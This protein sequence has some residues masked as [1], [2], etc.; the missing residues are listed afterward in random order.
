ML[1]P[2]G[3][4]SRQTSRL[5]YRPKRRYLPLPFISVIFWFIYNHRKKVIPVTGRGGP[6][7]CE[8][9]RLPHFSRQSAHSLVVSLTLRPAALYPQEDFWYSLLLET[10]S[11]VRLEGLGKLKKST[12]SELEP[13]TFRLVA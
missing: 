2:K 5:N 6:W 1:L 10:E 8:T 7:G 11:T 9:S 4:L 12:S 13:A 3:K